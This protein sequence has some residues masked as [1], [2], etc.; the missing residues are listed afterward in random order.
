MQPVQCAI[1]FRAKKNYTERA[2]FFRCCMFSFTWFLFLCLQFGELSVQCALHQFIAHSVSATIIRECH[3]QMH[4][5]MIA[6]DLQK[7]IKQM[8]WMA[9]HSRICMRDCNGI[10]CE[11]I[12]FQLVQSFIAL[13]LPFFLLVVF[14]SL[15]QFLNW[16][17][18]TLDS[19][20]FFSLALP[21]SLFSQRKDN[22][23]VTYILYKLCIIVIK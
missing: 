5:K 14:L 21:F 15:I 22:F 12:P 20:I 10:C 18:C 1:V 13:S 2:R 3:Y 8:D 17:V 9:L 23:F 7:R 6:R 4:D 16:T 11:I 19:F